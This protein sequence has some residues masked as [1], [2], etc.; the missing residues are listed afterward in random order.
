M[1]TGLFTTIAITGFTVAFFHAAIPTHWLPFVLAGRAQR[2]NR[3][4]TLAIAAVAGG[5]H[6]LFTM[7]LGV[8][9]V[10]FGIA[11]NK[12]IGDWFPRI[13]GCVLI[14]FGFYYI[15]RQL[16]GKG[17][18]HAFSRHSHGAHGH[19]DLEHQHHH[20]DHEQG[21]DDG[22]SHQHEHVETSPI[23][24]EKERLAHLEQPLATSDR[25]AILSLL[26]LLTFSPC[27]GF[28]PVYLT[29]VKYGWIGFVLLSVI[30]AGATITGMVVFTWLTLMGI[31]KLNLK[32]LEK[33]EAGVMGTLLC[34]LGVL[35]II[36]ES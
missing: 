1:K 28:L 23:A 7:L 31:E 29:G 8:M 17:H 2:W 22:H 3:P 30:L 20:D 11:L 32:R 36:F 21:H 18:G 25:V 14:V 4:K 10:W 6:V 15:W 16:A 34:A 13:A 33:F 24:A 5:G 12:K 9:V 27:E 35:I 26:A 19:H